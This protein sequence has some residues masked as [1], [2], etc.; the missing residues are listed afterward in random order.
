MQA[1]TIRLFRIIFILGALLSL[2]LG[3]AEA[4]IHN[5]VH[6]SDRVEAIYDIANYVKWPQQ[7][8]IDTFRL[9]LLS[10]D[11]AL[12]RETVR[13]KDL[14]I[15]EKPVN[16]LSFKEEND[17][18][19]RSLELLFLQYRENWDISR[20]RKLIKGDRTLLMAENYPFY[21]CMVSFIFRDSLTEFYAFRKHF[22]EKDFSYSD[23]L[24]FIAEI[25]TQA[26][27]KRAYKHTE[28]RLSE[29]KKELRKNKKKLEKKQKK[30]QKLQ[31]D[32]SAKRERL[33]EQEKR[34]KAKKDSLSSLKGS[35]KAQ[36]QELANKK[37]TLREKAQELE[38]TRRS[39]QKQRSI[40]AEQK[41]AADSLQSHI[42]E[43]Q[44]RIKDQ[45]GTLKAQDTRITYQTYALITFGLLILIILAFGYLLRK[46]YQRIKAINTQLAEK[47]ETILDQNERIEDKNKEI[48]E[49]IT[50]ASKI[51]HAMLPS[52]TVLQKNFNDSSAIYIPR[53]IVSGD[54]YWAAEADGKM[55]WT[56]PDCTGH[57][58]PGA[59]MSMLGMAYLKEVVTRKGIH[60]PEKILDEVRD[61]IVR[62]LS[63][64]D[65]EQKAKDGMDMGLCTLDKESGM[66]SFAGANNPLYL[67]FGDDGSSRSFPE[68]SKKIED[69]D[70]NIAGI[71]VQVDKQPV[72]AHSDATP[73]TKR[74]LKVRKGDRLYLFSDG[75]ADQ[76][77]GK[78]GKKLKY[79]PFKT[80][81]M[82]SN[83]RSLKE[84]RDHL[85][86]KFM[87]WKGNYEQV[88][89]V[90]VL[91]VEI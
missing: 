49:S 27:W 11:S 1:S 65:K 9:G 70:G 13:Q 88:D 73:F 51:Q 62:S 3:K 2:A 26:D 23:K 60:S 50:Y 84:Q 24:P 55:I 61:M 30:L 81:I 54:F 19:E 37:K 82:D 4:Q 52:L 7:S 58:V 75:Y 12:Y 45:K 17:L 67:F 76:F 77:G 31:K 14:R 35:L 40:L 36:K 28:G 86:E 22:L 34:L 66:L 32:I 47:N 5:N 41:K 10:R 79:K 78:K 16:V 39:I 43:Q 6:D 90:V 71:E 33:Q 56:A 83:D 29:R 25:K 91:S 48:T 38:N 18:E 21:Q 46:N 59:M 44:D 72:G 63:S 53:D 8:D 80:M 87:E 89:D 57:G 85:H 74:E 69:K 64:E 42:T 15:N 20:V 68:D